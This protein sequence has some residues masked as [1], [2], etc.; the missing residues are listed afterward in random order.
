MLVG[1][2]DEFRTGIT[3]IGSTGITETGKTPVKTAAFSGR[4]VRPEPSPLKP[5]PGT[6]GAPVWVKMFAMTLPG[7]LPSPLATT[8]ILPAARMAGPAVGA[9]TAAPAAT[10]KAGA[11]RPTPGPGTTGLLPTTFNADALV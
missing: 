1:R 6:M 3:E 9:P 8:L 7:W 5:E 4:L 2:T 11:L 10:F